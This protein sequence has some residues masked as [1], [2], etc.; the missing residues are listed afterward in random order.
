MPV[1]GTLN[2]QLL[3]LVRDR[4]K[5]SAVRRRMRREALAKD[6]TAPSSAISPAR[7]PESALDDQGNAEDEAAESESET[8]DPFATDFFRDEAGKRDQ[9]MK[10]VYEKKTS[11]KTTKIWM[12]VSLAG[13]ASGRA[14]PPSS[15]Y[16]D[17]DVTYDEKKLEDSCRSNDLRAPQLRTLAQFS[18]D[19]LNELLLQSCAKVFRGDNNHLTTTAAATTMAATCGATVQH[20]AR[21]MWAQ[22]AALRRAGHDVRY[23][24]FSR[25]HLFHADRTQAQFQRRYRA[26]RN[27]GSQLLHEKLAL[28]TKAEA[29]KD[30]RAM[31]QVIRQLSPKQHGGKVRIRSEDG[32]PLEPA[33]EH[34]EISD[35]FFQQFGA[36]GAD[37]R[38]ADRR[39]PVIVDSKAVERQG[40]SELAEA[41]LLETAAGYPTS[42]PEK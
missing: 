29:A 37:V 7:F 8:E 9:E 10:Q 22:R 17:Q 23:G 25:H 34:A 21:A 18:A 19:S 4:K 42:S 24:L 3:R 12:A 36:A 13:I 14:P 26:L 1:S 20:S 11:K 40:L 41:F 31:C 38:S 39:D 6:R 2:V 15:D 33:E 30:P 27:Q 28:A 5:I 32:Q 16:F 35:Y